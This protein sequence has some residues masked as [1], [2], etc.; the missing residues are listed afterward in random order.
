MSDPIRL[1][2]VPDAPAEARLPRNV[3][4]EAALLGALMIDNR[5]VEDVQMTLGAQ[6][7]FEP[8]HGRIYEAILR[9][10]DRNMVAIR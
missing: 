7:F 8:L 6:H 2:P 3:E 10:A 9:L 4:A 5:I 1:N